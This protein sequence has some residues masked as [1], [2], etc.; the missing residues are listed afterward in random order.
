MYKNQL[1]ELAQRSCFNLPSYSCIREGPDH[2][3]R[4]KATVTFN[5]ESFESPIFCNTLRQAEHAAAEVALNTLSKRG[6]TQSL[7]ARI[8]DETGVCKNLLQ[9]TA[10]RAGVKLPIYSFVRSGP[11]HMP[12][13]VST[14]ELAGMSFTGES[15]KTKKQAEK[16]AAMAAWASLKQFVTQ[17]GTSSQSPSD[18]DEQLQII[19]ARAL[20]NAQ[21]DDTS[22]RTQAPQRV[23]QTCNSQPPSEMV[24]P[25]ATGRVRVIPFSEFSD[26]G[27]TDMQVPYSSSSSWTSMDVKV[28]PVSRQKQVLVQERG[29]LHI[30]EGSSYNSSIDPHKSGL[31]G[32]S[33][34]ASRFTT[35]G[36]GNIVQPMP[37]LHTVSINPGLDPHATCFPINQLQQDEK[38]LFQGGTSTIIIR[39]NSNDFNSL[40]KG[41]PLV[42]TPYNPMLWIPGNQWM[43][44]VSQPRVHPTITTF[45]PATS[46]A[47]RVRVRQT[48]PVCSAPPCPSESEEQV[49]E[50]NGETATRQAFSELKL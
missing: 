16:N 11:G 44:V 28:D 24:R 2:A 18:S 41:V 49:T 34:T 27:T 32:K 38:D 21:K 39:T 15:A 22:P 8:L 4:F 40:E 13:F 1:Q 43:S 17:G 5:G 6:P 25:V 35:H 33:T 20:M 26:Q 46:L 37:A 9:E 42:Q 47:P 7:A 30:I 14:V 50:T 23:Y 29:N 3:P 12:V 48:V 36:A 10:Q 45:K 19:I 31:P